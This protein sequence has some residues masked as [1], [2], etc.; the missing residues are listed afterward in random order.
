ML[1]YS[2]ISDETDMEE[3]MFKKIEFTGQYVSKIVS[4]ASFW[5]CTSDDDSVLNSD[6]S[7]IGQII[8]KLQ[9]GM[10]TRVQMVRSIQMAESVEEHR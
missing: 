9:R 2:C 5:H 10:F 1:E 7:N 4:T 8:M 3:L 6:S